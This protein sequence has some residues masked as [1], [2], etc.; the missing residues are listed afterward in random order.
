MS[1]KAECQR[2]GDFVRQEALELLSFRRQLRHS[3]EQKD[4]VERVL[5]VLPT[6]KECIRTLMPCTQTGTSLTLG[7][8]FKAK[9]M[10]GGG[11]SLTDLSLTSMKGL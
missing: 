3:L 11:V 7:S 5:A 4:T 6:R 1:R 8:A 9:K 10:A 2:L